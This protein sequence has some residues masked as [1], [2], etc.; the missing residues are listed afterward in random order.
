MFNSVPA[1]PLA[2]A[3]ELRFLR[4]D[5]IPSVCLPNCCIY[6]SPLELPLERID[7]PLCLIKVALHPPVELLVTFIHVFF[8]VSAPPFILCTQ[9]FRLSAPEQP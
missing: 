2:W 8:V 7:L 1:S 4:L 6:I 3:R 5:P 9:R